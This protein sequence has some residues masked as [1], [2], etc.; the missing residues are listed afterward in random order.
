MAGEHGSPRKGEEIYEDIS[1]NEAF[2]GRSD[3]DSPAPWMCNEYL[4]PQRPHHRRFYLCSGATIDVK[5]AGSTVWKG[6]VLTALKFFIGFG[7]GLLLNALFGEA[8]FLG[9]APLAVIGAVTNSNGVIYATLAGEFGDETDVGATS[10]LALN[11]GPFFT[12]IALGASGMGNFP[13]TD[14]IASIIPMVIG[15]IPPFNGFAL[16]AGMNFNNILRAGIS[17]IVLGLLTVLATGLLTFFLYSALRRKADPMGAAIGTTAGVATTTP[18]AVAMA[19]PSF[20]P[21]VETATA[22]T[23]AAVVITAV[24]CPLL[25]SWLSKVSRKWNEAHGI[26]A[27]IPVPEQEG[28]ETQP[29]A[30]AD[31]D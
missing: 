27:D 16:G 23:A 29:A 22:Q 7:L 30:T 11:D 12:M 24:L 18:T 5:M 21:Q 15:F 14:I 13:I 2:S 28:C 10:I 25:V 19:D 1:D 8:G 6:V 4:F 17:G 3:G 26:A 20:Q 9:L 31:L